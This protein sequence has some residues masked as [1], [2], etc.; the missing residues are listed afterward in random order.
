LSI[1]DIGQFEEPEA[2]LVQR[3]APLYRGKWRTL[4]PEVEKGEKMNI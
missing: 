1:E 3:K 2:V 4:P